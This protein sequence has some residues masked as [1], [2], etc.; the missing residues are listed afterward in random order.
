MIVQAEETLGIANSTLETAVLASGVVVAT[1]A[2]SRPTVTTADK[3]DLMLTEDLERTTDAVRRMIIHSML[4]ITAYDIASATT[5]TVRMPRGEVC[6]LT[7]ISDGSPVGQLTDLE[8]GA[9][10]K[11][12]GYSPSRTL[13]GRTS[14]GPASNVELESL[15]LGEGWAS[16]FGKRSVVTHVF[17]NRPFYGEHND[18]GSGQVL[19]IVNFALDLETSLLVRGGNVAQLIQAYYRVIRAPELSVI[20]NTP[21]SDDR[22]DETTLTFVYPGKPLRIYL[23]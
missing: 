17:L 3:L 23:N 13:V 14:L 10:L 16:P 19:T 15:G 21:Y 18:D 20:L 5:L 9:L 2:Q 1:V 7:Y 4:K 22:L 8:I 6:L 11:I 12:F